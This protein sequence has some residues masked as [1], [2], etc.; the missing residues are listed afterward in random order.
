MPKSYSHSKKS[1][2]IANLSSEKKIA[3]LKTSSRIFFSIKFS[4]QTG[5]QIET[6]QEMKNALYFLCIIAKIEQYKQKKSHKRIITQTQV[7]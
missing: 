1:G 7:K 3:S 2:F 4:E 5:L 6:L